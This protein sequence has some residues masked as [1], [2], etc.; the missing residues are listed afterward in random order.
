MLSDVDEEIGCKR[1]DSTSNVK[2]IRGVKMLCFAGRVN[3]KRALEPCELCMGL[4][5]A[6][7]LWDGIAGNWRCAQ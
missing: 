1:D 7:S 3:W 4:C 6:S 5:C 2:E